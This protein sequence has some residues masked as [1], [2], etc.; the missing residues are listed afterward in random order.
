[1]SGIIQIYVLC[2]IARI[3][4]YFVLYTDRTVV[5]EAI[6]HKLFGIAILIIFAKRMGYS[7]GELGFT[8]GKSLWNMLKGLAFGMAVYVLAYATEIL[9]LF[10][11]G[12]FRS[13]SAYVSAYAIDRNIGN[14][15]DFIFFLICIIGNIVNVVMEEGIFR[16]LFVK[17]L[18]DRCAFLKA[19][20]V[21]SFLFGIWHV[22]SPVRNYLEGTSSLAG[23]IM[24]A[25]M[26][27]FTSTLV[28]LK[29]VMLT[30][31]T[32]NLYMAM[33]DHFVNNT[34]VN[35]LH[36]VSSTGADEMMTIRV[37]V[38]QT[39]SFIAVLVW[40]ARRRRA[41]RDRERI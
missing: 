10:S 6:V 27:L 7:A 39:I 1:M 5:G 41:D 13:L 23:M 3:I 20:F 12:N 32:G 22:V 17:M 29:F 28:G 9:I 40:Y 18:R 36:V 14:R 34:I 15:T 38:A 30:S 4:E 16:G 11:Q 2:F 25:L 37:S 31:G 35:L 8:S 21:S 19:A 24:S 26:L 33:G